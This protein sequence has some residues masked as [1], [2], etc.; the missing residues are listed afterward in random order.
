MKDYANIA[1]QYAK[2]IQAKK[3]V[4]CETARQATRRFLNDIKNSKAKSSLFFFDENA[5]NEICSFAESLQLPDIKKSIVLQDWQIFIYAN[6]WGWKYKDN[7][8]RRRFRTA[9]IEV[10]RKNGKTSGFLF[11][12]ILY[13]FLT[14]TASE[15]YLAS[16][17]IEQ[18]EKSF[19][20]IEEIINGNSELKEICKCYS[21]AITFDNSK[22]TFFSP[23]TTA[24]DG[25]RNS[26]SILDEYH[27]YADDKI[28]TAFRYGGRARLNSCVCIITSAG[29]DISGACYAEN[30]KAKSILSGVVEDESYFSIIYSYDEGDDGKDEN[31]FIKANP[32][33]NTFLKK[34]VLLSDLNDAIFTPSHQ[35]DFKSKTCGIWTNQ[36]SNWISL[37]TWNFNKIN[38]VADLG[39]EELKK[40]SCY[41]GVDLA[42]VNDIAAY[43]LCWNVNGNFYFRHHFYIP[44]KT[45]EEKYHTNNVNFPK[46]INEKYITATHGETIDYDFIYNDIAEDYRK[47]GIKEIALDVWQSKDLINKLNENIP[48]I[49]Y[50]E[51]SQSLKNMSVPTKDY[52]SAILSHKIIDYNPVMPWFIGNV[53]IN[54]DSN[55]NYKPEKEN[56]SSNKKI[57]GVI[58]SLM[59]FSRCKANSDKP[60]EK[61]QTF[62][63]LMNSF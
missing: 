58:S 33:L 3:I 40:Y 29:N 43:S 60:V 39:D 34:D 2:D 61:T 62:G 13:D 47:F 46:W 7:H 41:G 49:V 32:A 5:V 35:S 36:K 26:F 56:K 31:N 55:G 15:S 30:K 42:T 51:F 1:V 21:S 59:A 44:E 27:E 11:P 54:P 52:E 53:K 50:V 20:E 25:Y 22:I 23:Q 17:T 9:Y 14:E 10:A 63:E 16:A 24:L 12:F 18:S 8:E 28:L 6:V 38:N 57:D 19:P 45:I 37:E 4:A 48:D